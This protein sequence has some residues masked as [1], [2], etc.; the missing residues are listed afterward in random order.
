MRRRRPSAGRTSDGPVGVFDSGIGGLTVLDAIS[1]RMPAESLVYFGDTAHVPYGTKSPEAVAR[2]SSEVARYLEG[3]GVKA[4]VVACNTASAVALPTVRRAVG[5]PVIGVILPGAKAAAEASRSGRIGIIGT[6]ATI[7]SGA[8]TR[9]VKGLRP[10]ARVT[11]AACPLFVPFVE[12]GWWDG[13]VIEAV[14][15]RYLGTMR[16]SGVDTLILGCTH[17]PLLRGVVAAEMGKA[18]TLID[19]AEQTAIE[20]WALL[21]RLGLERT[22]GKG[23]ARF[24]VSDGPGRFRML[25]RRLIG[26]DVDVRRHRFDG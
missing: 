24:I 6:E 13:S 16:R 25:A 9:A 1:R 23:K 3:L 15:R 8:Y 5:V 17:Y 18:V 2:Y 19:S 20:L 7:A 10:K 14:A 22:S 12:E 26:K 4:L 21:R 11:G